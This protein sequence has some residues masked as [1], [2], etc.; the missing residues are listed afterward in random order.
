MCPPGRV[1]LLLRGALYHE[2][3]IMTSVMS[4]RVAVFLAVAGIIAAS[5]YTG[6]QQPV[7]S[8]VEVVQLDVV[9]LDKDR[10]PVRG[11]SQQDFT[12][13]E[14]GTVRP[15]VG[16]AA[17]ELAV[18]GSVDLAA[19][20]LEASRG[21]VTNEP[22]EQARLVVI[23]FDRTIPAGPPRSGSISRSRKSVPARTCSL[24]KPA[25]WIV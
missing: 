11:L 5:S 24:S 25:K 9:V 6:A 13:L 4:Y 12:I 18:P 7:R 14:E 17:I 22:D 16:F 19:A 1:S 3:R 21:V 23:V 20:A 10:R 15:I 2:V 8:G